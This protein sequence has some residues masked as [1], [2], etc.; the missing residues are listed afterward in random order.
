MQVQYSAVDLQAQSKSARS[1]QTKWRA[2]QVNDENSELKVDLW[3]T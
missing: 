1:I 3:R 2:R